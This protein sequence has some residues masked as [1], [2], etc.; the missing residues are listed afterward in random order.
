M[1][2][3]PL[4]ASSSGPRRACDGEAGTRRRSTRSLGLRRRSLVRPESYQGRGGS[5]NLGTN[6]SR[7]TFALRKKQGR[8]RTVGPSRGS[9]ATEARRRVVS[10]CTLDH[11]LRV[12]RPWAVD[13]PPDPRPSSPYLA[14]SCAPRLRLEQPAKL[15]GCVGLGGVVVVALPRHRFQTQPLSVTSTRAKRA[16]L[17]VGV[18]VALVEADVVHIFW[19]HSNVFARMQDTC[20][21]RKGGG[22][23][24][25]HRWDA[26][27]S[28]PAL[29][30]LARCGRNVE[31]AV[32]V[33]SIPPDLK[34]LWERLGGV[35]MIVDLQERGAQS[36]KEVA[37]DEV[38]ALE[39]MNSVIDREEPAVAVLLSGD[40]GFREAVDRMLKKGWGVEV[41][42]FSKGFARRLRGIATGSG[43][44]G[45]YVELDPWWTQLVYLQGLE[46][47]II[48][49]TDVLDLTGRPKV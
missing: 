4:G 39:M 28:F 49:R 22:L 17:S 19:D 2:H 8:S 43:G 35:G 34:G 31:K 47:P 13:L 26:R 10:P 24:P 21:D 38:L 42:S 16:R 12:R 18:T 6:H 1:P 37:V 45:K 5:R 11:R 7:P 44:R 40:G 3:P 9:A 29:F 48:R 20:D 41:V 46:G 15:G 14:P 27:V 23:E 36:G 32:A 30:E 33:G 25:G